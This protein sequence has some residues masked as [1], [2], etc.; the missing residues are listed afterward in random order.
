MWSERLPDDVERA[1]EGAFDS[2]VPA[3]S[4]AMYARW[5]ELETWLRALA[6][7]ELRAQRGESWTDVLDPK[8]LQRQSKEQARAYM[9]SPDWTDPLA[10]LDAS[11]LLDLLDKNWPLFEPS[12][13]SSGSWQGRRGEL[14]EIRNRIGH[15]RRPHRD[16]LAR[17]EQTLRDLEHGAVRALRA[18]NRRCRPDPHQTSDPVVA[19]WIVGQHPV[20][21]RL[22]E[23]AE[24][25][26]GTSLQLTYSVRPWVA[27]LRDERVSGSSGV[28]WHASFYMGGRYLR[29]QDLWRD[30][31]L[32][33][34]ARRL[35]VHLLADDPHQAEFTFAAVDEPQDIA[36]AIGHVFNPVLANSSTR[37]L[38][39]WDDLTVEVPRLLRP[40]DP[41]VLVGSP[42]NI[43]N[44]DTEPVTIFN[45]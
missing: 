41:R 17:L 12:L 16:D 11:L 31:Y 29:L 18:Y 7:V 4:A 37:P 20:A 44:D 2:G 26:Y 45:A 14:L 33:S 30:P 39:G 9:A 32:N 10:Y 27:E 40:N 6:Y 43:V 28:L 8:A 34:K 23:H 3:R 19:G 13:I 24:R 35:L 25:Q 22:L 21:R 42:W 36:D 1:L 38:P 15:L 5:W